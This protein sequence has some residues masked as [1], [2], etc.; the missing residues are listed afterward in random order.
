LTTAQLLQLLLGEIPCLKGRLFP[1]NAPPHER[2]CHTP[3]SKA[4][5]SQ[6]EGDLHNIFIHVQLNTKLTELII[7]NFRIITS[8]SLIRRLAFAKL[9][10]GWGINVRLPSASDRLPS[11]S[12]Y[13]V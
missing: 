12:I 10:A 13:Y 6:P 8:L 11:S 5:L 3:K 1:F 9:L 4:K 2:R 7:N